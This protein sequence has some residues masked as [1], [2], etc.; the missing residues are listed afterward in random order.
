MVVIGA[1]QAGLSVAR[2]LVRAGLRPGQEFVVLDAADGPG[3]AW[4]ERWDTLT[5]DTVNGIFALPGLDLP[6]PEPDESANVA[7]PAYFAM[8]EDTFDLLVRRPV[9]V[10]EVRDAGDDTDDL[11]VVTADGSLRARGL[12]N[13]TGTWTRPF[14]PRV[15]GQPEF[16]GRQLHTHDWPG[17][18]PFADARVV[19]VGGGISAVGHLGELDQVGATT[20]WVTRR[21]PRWRTEPFTTEYGRGVVARIDERVR[22]GLRPRSVVRETGL[23]VTAR[24]RDLR[25]RGVLDRH[26]MFDLVTLDGAAWTDDHGHVTDA[27]A[28][29]AIV[30][31][32]GF[33]WALDHLAPLDLRSTHGGIVMDGTRVVADARIHLVGYGPSASTVGANR[34]GRAAVSDLLTHLSI[35]GA[36]SR[37][38]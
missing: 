2:H 12:V 35:P 18:A 28:A 6:E 25:G 23:P 10:E 36:N 30:W 22:R 38:A 33:R 34:A 9:T 16:T 24:V 3:G 31:A 19:V 17:P 27:F 14:W 26:P 37:A 20:R 29:D 1:G 32:T 13:A 11:V 7:L 5:M 15:P 8:F 4:R 21:P